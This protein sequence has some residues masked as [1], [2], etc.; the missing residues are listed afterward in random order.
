MKWIVTGGA[1]FIGCNT[2]KRLLDS[3][4]SVVAIDNLSRRGTAANLSWLR[5]QG[6][7]EFIKLDIRDVDGLQQVFAQHSDVDVILHLAAQVAV[8]TSVVNPREDFEINTVGTFNVLEATRT[9]NTN[10]IFLYASTNKVYGKIEQAGIELTNGKYAYSQLPN[11]VPESTPLDFYSPYGCSKGAADQYV[12]DYARIYGLRTVVFRQSCIA[13]I[14]QLGIEDQGWVAWFVIAATLG[15]P[16]TLYGDGRQ[17]RD[18]LFVNDLVDAYLHAVAQIDRTSGTVYNIGGGPTN[19]LSLL[20]LL[21]FLENRLGRKIPVR[22]AD[23]R[24]GDQRVFIADITKAQRDFGWAPKVDIDMGL[25]QLYE[26]VCEETELLHSVLG[27]H[28]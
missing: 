24:P 7:F 23:W 10:P 28:L 27:D 8:T 9:L 14:R 2:I 15:S 12:H 18:V 25:A 17:V 6:D 21:T 4:H 26:W 1:G 16:I 3:G 19:Q 20:E 11:G 13:G 22:Y 5:K